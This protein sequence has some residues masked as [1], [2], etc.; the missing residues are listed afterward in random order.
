MPCRGLP[1]PQESSL[2]SVLESVRAPCWR[3]KL[4]HDLGPQSGPCESFLYSLWFESFA[5]RCYM[6]SWSFLEHEEFS[7]LV[8]ILDQTLARGRPQ[9]EPFGLAGVVTVQGIAEALFIPNLFLVVFT[10]SSSS[11]ICPIFRTFICGFAQWTFWHIWVFFFWPDVPWSCRDLVL[12]ESAFGPAYMPLVDFRWAAGIASHRSTV[13]TLT[14]LPPCSKSDRWS[15]LEVHQGFWLFVPQH[16]WNSEVSENRP[17]QHG[18]SSLEQHASNVRSLPFYFRNLVDLQ[19]MDFW[20][21]ASHSSP[22][23][24]SA[25]SCLRSPSRLVCSGG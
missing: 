4:K 25:K 15:T 22:E 7:L 19:D 21:R 2:L 11:G 10:I 20:S 9:L 17:S 12:R 8:S 14:C 1:L 13:E 23:G 18:V 6:S 16:Q 3:A 24:G 5:I